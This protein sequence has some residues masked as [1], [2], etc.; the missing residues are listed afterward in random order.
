ML[1]CASVYQL[2]WSSA[3]KRL[4]SWLSFVM[5]NC[6]VVTSPFGILG[7]MWCLIASFPDLYHFLPLI[8]AP[9]KTWL[10]KLQNLLICSHFLA[11]PVEHAR[12]IMFSRY[13]CV[14]STKY[15][16]NIAK[17]L[18]HSLPSVHSQRRLYRSSRAYSYIVRKRHKKV[19]NSHQF[20]KWFVYKPVL[21]LYITKIFFQNSKTLT[22]DNDH[23]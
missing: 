13:D 16:P 22:S 9:F 11:S 12:H 1:S 5:S 23:I 19:V 14:N 20:N 3:R 2:L 17:L 18:Y 15:S 4:T 10:Q 8:V 21:F 6:E 7:Q